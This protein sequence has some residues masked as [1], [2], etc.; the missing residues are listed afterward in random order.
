MKWQS[1]LTNY[2]ID[3]IMNARKEGKSLL[4][5]YCY[6]EKDGT[7]RIVFEKHNL[8]TEQFYDRGIDED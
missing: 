3:T 4:K 5:I 7:V 8:I 6:G 2:M 1:R